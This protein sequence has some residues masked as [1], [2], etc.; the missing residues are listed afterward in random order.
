MATKKK[1][2]KKVQKNETCFEDDAGFFGQDFD[3]HRGTAITKSRVRH[4]S[5]NQQTQAIRKAWL[6]SQRLEQTTRAS[7]R[8]QGRNVQFK[9][10]K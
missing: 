6:R 2:K 3:Q 10:G 1:S 8:T 7:N 5:T 4:A 9:L